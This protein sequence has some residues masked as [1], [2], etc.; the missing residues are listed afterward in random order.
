MSSTITYGALLVALYP[1]LP[2][3]FRRMATAFVVVLVLAVGTSRLF[4]GVHFVS[5]VIGGY[6]LG[7]AWLFGAVAAF[8]TWN[9][10]ERR[11]ALRE[12]F[13]RRTLP[14]TGPPEVPSTKVAIPSVGLD[15][16]AGHD[17]DHR[18]RGDD[19]DDKGS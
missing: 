8:E 1:L 17:P 2:P 6:V 10:E 4:L 14:S 12:R 18:R 7:L 5:D 11:S 16:L 3:R 9:V 15:A 13:R 19:A